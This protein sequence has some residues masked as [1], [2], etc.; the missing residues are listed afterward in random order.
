MFF[1]LGICLSNVFCLFEHYISWVWR[2]HQGVNANPWLPAVRLG[3]VLYMI[4]IHG[5]AALPFRRKALA[6]LSLL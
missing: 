5:L 6:K 2:F 4:L 3:V 1:S